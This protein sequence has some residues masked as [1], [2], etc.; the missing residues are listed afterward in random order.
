MITLDLDHLFKTDPHSNKIPKKVF[1]WVT[2]KEKQFP[3]Q[4]QISFY[5]YSD[6]IQK[7]NLL[8]Y[9]KT[10]FSKTVLPSE[11]AGEV[12]TINFPLAD[13]VW[14][15]KIIGAKLPNN[16]FIPFSDQDN[17]D[18]NDSK[19]LGMERGIISGLQ[20]YLDRNDPSLV[21]LKTKTGNQ[22]PWG[23][24]WGYKKSEEYNDTDNEMVEIQC[25]RNI[26][27]EWEF[28]GTV[29]EFMDEKI[30]PLLN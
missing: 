25:D 7:Q 15:I 20:E 11:Y 14:Y 10:F 16:T 4:Y 21:L 26:N 24:I 3:V 12:T 5:Q 2:E 1:D 30:K 17:P 6:D 23:R 13:G 18:H 22:K 28:R 29:Q 8:C 27:D 9:E 19:A